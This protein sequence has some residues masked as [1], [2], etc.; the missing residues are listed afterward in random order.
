MIRRHAAVELGG[1]RVAVVVGEGPGQCSEIV[2]LATTGPQETLS[3]IIGALNGLR[4]QGWDFESFGLACFGPLE[5]DRSSAQYGRVLATP[6]PGWTGADVAGVLAAGLG[7][8]V[9]IETD[10]N[11]A[12]VGEGRWGACRGLRDHTYITAGTGVGAGVCVGGAP[13]HGLLHPEAGHLRPMRDRDL[14]PFAGVCG[15]HGDCV[16]GLASGPAI[17]E[18][19][20]R[21]PAGLD[22]DHA[23]WELAGGYLGQLC[24]ALALIVSP[25]R[26]VLGGGVGRRPKVL[27][28][29]RRSLAAQ[30]GG[31][32]ARPTTGDMQTYLVGPG[33][34]ADS[35]L[36][37]ALALAQ[38]Q[39]AQAKL[40]ADA[41]SPAL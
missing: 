13:V 32:L 22:P 9:V 20:G 7:V 4:A 5:L 35:G 37:G 8:P 14:D 11:A 19:V 16:E 18:R 36:Y 28:A 10:V 41:A 31:Y 27:E 15:W 39:G 12:A 2:R 24:A 6:K 30:L 3:S 1:T 33:L 17:A 25:R 23:V 34:G 38:D 21:D 26:I 40:S 29:A